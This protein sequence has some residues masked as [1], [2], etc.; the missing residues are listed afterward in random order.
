M[1]M[2]VVVGLLRIQS[3]AD[4]GSHTGSREMSRK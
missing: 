4:V 2:V 1:L 3:D